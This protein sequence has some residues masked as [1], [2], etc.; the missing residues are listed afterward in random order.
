MQPNYFVV[1]VLPYMKTCSIFLSGSN[2]SSHPSPSSTQ[3]NTS[4]SSSV[5]N[6]RPSTAELKIR[7]EQHESIAP[8]PQAQPQQRTVIEYA[9]VCMCPELR[10]SLTVDFLFISFPWSPEVAQHVFF[11]HKVKNH[12]KTKTCLSVLSYLVAKETFL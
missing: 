11:C 3:S 1:F 9:E 12:K 10:I 7:W 5:H 6:K 4:S 2:T 8:H